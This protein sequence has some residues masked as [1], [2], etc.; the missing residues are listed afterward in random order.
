M[1]TRFYICDVDGTGAF[2]TPFKPRLASLISGNWAA[3][4]ARPDA[5]AAAGKILAYA[6]VTP[7]QHTTIVADAGVTYVPFEDAGGNPKTLK[8]YVGDVSAA[9]RTL[10][11]NRLEAQGVPTDD[12]SLANTIGAVVRRAIKRFALRQLLKSDDWTESLDSLVS[13]MD[14][15][16][17]TRIANTLTA[18]G[19]DTSVIQGADTIRAAIRKI[20]GQ[21]VAAIRNFLD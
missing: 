19:F 3:F 20:V 16:K 10:I 4:D 5:A 12:F 21:N 1:A 17:R 7:A 11:S 13:A 9:N 15:Q 14:P 6:D 2:A 18:K 8:D